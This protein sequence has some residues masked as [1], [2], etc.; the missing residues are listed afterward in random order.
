[1]TTS[2]P[3]DYVL[4]YD[5]MCPMC[6]RAAG[7]LGRLGLLETVS[8]APWPD[9]GLEDERL[10]E[11][12]RSELVLYHPACK[13]LYGGIDGLIKLAELQ[14]KMAFP[15]MLLKLPGVKPLADVT[16]KMVS[17]NRRILSPRSASAIAC[18][19]DPP[20][21]LKYRALLWLVL[22][23]IA[24]GGSALF[25]ASLALMNPEKSF[26]ETAWQLTI[27]A[28]SGWALNL[29]VFALLT[30]RRYGEFVQQNLV[31][32]AIGIFWLM[33]VAL[34]LLSGSVLGLPS[35]VLRALAIAGVLA[36]SL[37]MFAA[38]RHRLNRLGFPGWMPWL[39]LALL[40]GAGVP[41]FVYFGLFQME[42]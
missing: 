13:E 42:G 14:G 15:R 29:I 3:H 9:A 33:P 17:L 6:Q 21:S 27:A 18:A 20:F 24:F 35:A 1:M 12:L 25:G 8:A 39:W 10:E 40:E 22:L 31:V 28:G 38:I 41:L 4:L 11:R 23:G 37:V 26:S 36:D 32:M 30:G 19:C 2:D 34:A 7:M 16:Y 5:G